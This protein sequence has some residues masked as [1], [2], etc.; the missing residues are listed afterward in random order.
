[1]GMSNTLM[2]NQPE[3]LVNNY[4]DST[5]HP[6]VS[7]SLEEDLTIFRKLYKFGDFVGGGSQGR[8]YEVKHIQTGQIYAAKVITLNDWDEANRLMDDA[9][10]L[11]KI[12]HWGI[13]Q[14]NGCYF[15]LSSREDIEL[16]LVSE[17]IYGQSLAELLSRDSRRFTE[18]RIYDIGR[19]CQEVLD[20]VHAEGI[21]HRDIKPAN[22]MLT[23]DG[24]VKIIDFSL[25]K[26]L[27][28]KSRASSMGKG[29]LSYMAPEQLGLV[30]YEITAK[31]DEYSLGL[32]LLSLARRQ[33]REEDIRFSNPLDELKALRRGGQFSKKFT[34]GLEKLLQEKPAKRKNFLRGERQLV[35]A[36]IHSSSDMIPAPARESSN[37]VRY[38][39]NAI[40][41]PPNWAG[42]ILGTISGI[43]FSL[44]NIP[45]GVAFGIG[46]LALLIMGHVSNGKFS[47]IIS[48]PSTKDY[49][50]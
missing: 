17:R 23:E 18:E 50:K 47:E 28:E 11:A 48:P 44:G 22:I 1:M 45:G 2:V 40:I 39:G 3:L 49:F 6:E 42:G 9:K 5:N 19:Q 37:L 30:D 27:G 7:P 38:I 31:T 36:P 21:F 4:G 29:T 13:P 46:S 8:V 20:A 33:V 35:K 12:T 15:N 10:A 32:T 26:F 34:K 24:I 16:I 25:A 41:N 14:S 43:S